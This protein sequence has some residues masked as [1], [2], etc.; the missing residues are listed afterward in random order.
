MAAVHTDP[1][2]KKQP[3]LKESDGA[4][5]KKRENLPLRIVGKKSKHIM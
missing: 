4:K 5:I 3:W 1:K 2:Y